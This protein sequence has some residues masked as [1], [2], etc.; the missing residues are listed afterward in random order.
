MSLKKFEQT[1]LSFIQTLCHLKLFGGKTTSNYIIDNIFSEK[2]KQTI[3]NIEQEEAFGF[4]EDVKANKM[5]EFLINEN[6][7]VAA[8]LLNKCS[9][10]RMLEIT[11]IL[12]SDNLKV[13]AKHLVSVKNNPCELM[14]KFE[15]LIK[16]KLVIGETTS[17]AS[18]KSNAPKSIIGI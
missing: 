9:E 1:L 6:E 15:A 14:D 11:E 13:M 5:K 18:K 12:P 7:V 4:I 10:E 17:E 8:F 16:E 2:E 3:F